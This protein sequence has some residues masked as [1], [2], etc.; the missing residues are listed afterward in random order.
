VAHD[1]IE[2]CIVGAGPRG[3]SVLERLCAIAGE[4]HPDRGHLTVHLVDPHVRDGSAVW[5]TSQARDLLMNTV[6]SQITMFPD[7]SVDCAGPVVPGPS[8]YDWARFL[9]QIDSFDQDVPDWVRREGAR[10][11]PDDYPTRAFY[12]HY[13][14]WVLR[15]LMRTTPARVDIRTHAVTATALADGCDGRQDLT[16][17]DGTVLTGLHSVV[18]TQGHLPARITGPE[19]GLAAYAAEHQLHYLP[20]VNPAEADLD[21]LA[22]GQP[23]AVR[24]MGLNFFDYMALLTSGR[25]G[26]FTRG[27]DERLI[28]QPSGDEPRLI[29][30]SRRGV[31]YHSRGENQKGPFGRYGLSFLTPAVIRQMRAQAE[32]GRPVDFR[33]RVWPLIDRDVRAVYYAR[34]I[35]DRLS[36]RHG[37]AFMHRYRLLFADG[38]FP[39]PPADPLAIRETAPELALLA[40]FGVGEHERWKWHTI[41]RPYGDRTFPSS[42]SYQGWLVDYLRSDVHEALRGNV[43]SPLKAAVDIMRDLRNEIRLVVDHG[44]VCGDSY[45]DDLQGWYTPLNAFVSIGPPVRRVEELIALIEA[46]TIRVLGPGMVVETPDDGGGFLV[47]S[48]R[49]AEPGSRVRALIEARMPEP[50]IRLTTDPL[51]SGL[52][53][54]GECVLHRIPV[55][56]GGYYETGGLAVT[57]QPY[58]LLDARRRPHP[59]R[60]AFGV[61][62]ET[63][64]WV[65]AAGIRPGVNSVI[66]SDADAVAQAGL[67][68]ANRPGAVPVAGC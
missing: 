29:A 20:P 17:S 27:R 65:T 38:R 45:R 2:I 42:A 61:P 14:Q 31:P 25:G 30:G 23:V 58:N 9:A 41:A 1:A 32:A 53:A 59:R 56:G 40:Q 22:P 48:S 19:T 57:A 47:R 28:Y 55:R 33:T 21:S 3:L 46:G 63:V 44:G 18:L 37:K 10:L 43:R 7:E 12:G 11:G 13:L 5:R 68:T 4:P 36:E 50:D 66:L 51:V 64:H 15:H 35:A 26:W 16:L 39:E 49:I 54:A 34:L 8:L 60:F 6:T 52:L 62:T 24:G 67:A